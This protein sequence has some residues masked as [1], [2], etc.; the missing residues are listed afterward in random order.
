MA[1][2]ES[3]CRV[4]W[5]PWDSTESHDSSSSPVRP[6]S[7]C[8]CAESADFLNHDTIYRIKYNVRSC[9]CINCIWNQNMQSFFTLEFT[10]LWTCKIF[11]TNWADN[12]TYFQRFR[13]EMWQDQASLCFFFFP[14]LL[15]SLIGP[16]YYLLSNRGKWEL[17]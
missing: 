9:W 8:A 11:L 13:N 17:A 2:S 12:L 4:A 1:E 15:L 3:T 14:F 7:V 16:I 6:D 5:V 10:L